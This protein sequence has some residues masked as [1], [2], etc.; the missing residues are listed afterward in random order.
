MSS[1]GPSR[2]PSGS[3][4]SRKSRSLRMTDHSVDI[5]ND[6]VAPDRLHGRTTADAVAY[7]QGVID[8][9]D[10]HVKA[11]MIRALSCPSALATVAAAIAFTVIEVIVPGLPS[12]LT[13]AVLLYMSAVVTFAVAAFDLHLANTEI[14]RRVGP[15]KRFLNEIVDDAQKAYFNDPFSRS[16]SPNFQT[17]L[18]DS[19]WVSL[20]NV[21]LVPDDLIQMRD[22]M[23]AP[24]NLEGISS[25]KT[26]KPKRLNKG[27]TLR[28]PTVHPPR[29]MAPAMSESTARFS[30][31]ATVEPNP[32]NKSD[33]SSSSCTKIGGLSQKVVFRVLECPLQNHISE[34][35]RSPKPFRPENTLSNQK[36]AMRLRAIQITICCVLLAVIYTVIIGVLKGS[37]LSKRVFVLFI[38]Q[39]LLC[40]I[41]SLGLS[42]LFYTFLVDAFG[43]GVLIQTD[44]DLRKVHPQDSSIGLG[45]SKLQNLR[46]LWKERRQ[47]FYRVVSEVFGLGTSLTRSVNPFE[48]LGQITADGIVSEVF[49]TPEHVLIWDRGAPVVLDLIADHELPNHVTF[50]RNWVHHF[51][52]LKPLGLSTLLT[53]TCLE[54][55]ELAARSPIAAAAPG[56]SGRNLTEH[57]AVLRDQDLS[58]EC[59]CQI[60]KA[61]GFPHDFAI[62]TF[63]RTQLVHLLAIPTTYSVSSTVLDPT[64]PGSQITHMASSVMRHTD[65]GQLQLFSRG[66]PALIMSHCDYVWNRNESIP[67]SSS[68]RKKTFDILQHWMHVDFKCVAFAYTPVAP[69]LWPK[70][71]T[72]SV[73]PVVLTCN[74]DDGSSLVQGPDPSVLDARD[75]NWGNAEMEIPA[76]SLAAYQDL[77]TG[78]ILLG[79]TASRPQPKPEMPYVIEDLVKAGIRFVFFSSTGRRKS[80][81]FTSKLGLESD[82]NFFISL[83]DRTDAAGPNMATDSALNIS[84]LPEGISKVRDHIHHVDNVPLLVS[85]FTDSTPDTSR[86]MISILQENGESVLCIGSS[87]NDFNFKTF[88]Q[89]DVAISLEPRIDDDHA[90][91]GRPPKQ[92]ESYLE[93]AKHMNSLPCAFALPSSVNIRTY[94]SGII[95]QSRNL[96]IHATQTYIFSQA[97]FMSIMLMSTI[98]V[99]LGMPCVFDAR[100]TV[101]LVWLIIPLLS[102][103]LLL[104]HPNRQT[105]QTIMEK[106]AA[107]LSSVNRFT[108][109]FLLRFI[110]SILFCTGVYAFYLNEFLLNSPK[111]PL[112]FVWTAQPNIFLEYS[113]STKDA[114]L[115][116]KAYTMFA[117]VYCLVWL[118]VG[119]V[120]RNDSVFRRNPLVNWIW[121]I[122]C[123]VALALQFMFTWGEVSSVSDISGRLNLYPFVG[124]LV[125]P[126]IT[127]SIDEAVK[128][129]DRNHYRRHQQR[130]R[131]VFD[132]KLGMH[133]PK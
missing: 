10:A 95:S 87:L 47:T 68:F 94:L 76:D 16:F 89:S 43:N 38:Q 101:F 44:I 54:S 59:L 110:P 29:P 82:W 93:F 17:V 106:N 116:A 15:A 61:V 51:D 55:T 24:C 34:L 22:G 83:K 124:L 25:N 98:S 64:R 119:F 1:A 49:S 72:S 122:C 105:M 100:Q 80:I 12:V 2:A 70:F 131:I 123:C 129:H 74:A 45:P 50:E 19:K 39:P 40:V 84:K 41:P 91:R 8:T 90:R 67:F 125:W 81:A 85:L 9:T 128:N 20:P 5:G 112:M 65:S 60:G 53:A 77:L 11:P 52:S 7:L 13:S 115:L 102:L 96:L 103:P 97:C 21:A 42:E 37:Q 46:V 127:L 14:R 69:K 31:F 92:P 4:R 36:K 104:S 32:A 30:E 111:P 130:L 63:S 120:Y 23:Q 86:E 58:S 109:Y 75:A 71:K 99:C 3:L 28:L 117:F 133:S 121:V 26:K 126:I 18:R 33:Q 27:D 62:R 56:D 6:H 108:A 57:E 66:D 73:K 88:L 107:H 132:T 79:I 35:T 113:D 48:T 118:S 114:V 78:Q